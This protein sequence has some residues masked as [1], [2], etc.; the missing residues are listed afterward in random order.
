MIRTCHEIL[1]ELTFASF[2]VKRPVLGLLV[3]HRHPRERNQCDLIGTL[4]FLK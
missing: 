2:F 1:Q 4:D 3:Y